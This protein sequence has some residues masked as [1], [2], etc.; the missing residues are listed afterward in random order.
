M[1]LCYDS[2]SP[3]TKQVAI[4]S[5]SRELECLVCLYTSPNCN[6]KKGNPSW[7]IFEALFHIM[8]E[9]KGPW[10]SFHNANCRLVV[11]TREQRFESFHHKSCDGK[12]ANMTDQTYWWDCGSFESS[13]VL[14][15]PQRV[16]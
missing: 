2:S 7:R 1:K 5:S 16:S 14:T 9:N 4:S 12:Y 8:E 3:I 11:V 6:V 15:L 13:W 10:A